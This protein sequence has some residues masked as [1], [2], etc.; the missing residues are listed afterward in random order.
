MWSR[1]DTLTSD[2]ARL[3]NDFTAVIYLVQDGTIAVF[4]NEAKAW[5]KSWDPRVSYV[6]NLVVI[7][8]TVE[9]LGGQ[10]ERDHARRRIVEAVCVAIS[11]VR[12]HIVE[13]TDWNR[14]LY[15]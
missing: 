15:V 7:G 12:W 13:S 5:D 14:I 9:L 6:P 4:D 10:A 1:N 3:N 8:L 2:R 11:S